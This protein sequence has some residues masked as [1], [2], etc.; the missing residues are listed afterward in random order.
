M[1]SIFLGDLKG[2]KGNE[3]SNK[4]NFD[5]R[6]FTPAKSKIPQPPMVW[7]STPSTDSNVENKKKE[8]KEKN[9]TKQTTDHNKIH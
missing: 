6:K 9:P 5:T 8:E 4:D 3:T 2:G 7:I 1:I